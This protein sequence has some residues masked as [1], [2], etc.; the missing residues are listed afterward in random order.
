MKKRNSVAML[1]II[2]LSILGMSLAWIQFATP[3]TPHFGGFKKEFL[4]YSSDEQTIYLTIIDRMAEEWQSDTS[5]PKKRFLSLNGKDA[6]DDLLKL[7]R[8][9]NMEV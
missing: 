2:T 1:G 5:L 3:T 4:Q 7:L 9:K 6:P 8:G